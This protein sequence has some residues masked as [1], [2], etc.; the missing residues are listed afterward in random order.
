[1]KIAIVGTRGIPAKYGGFE[2]FAEELSI[3]LVKK[4]IEVDVYCDYESYPYD[5]YK[6]V[7]LKFLDITKTSHPLK[8][9]FQSIVLAERNGSDVILCCGCGGF[10]ALLRH[11]IFCKQGI[12]ITNTDGIEHRRTKWNW[13]LRQCGRFALEYLSVQF[14]N[15][16]IADSEGIRKYLLSSYP[17]SKKKIFTIEYGAYLSPVF[18]E[19]YL[20]SLN[21]KVKE[22][23]LIVSRLEPE[24]NV[25]LII[26]GY[27]KSTS[28]YPLLIVGNLK[29]SKYVNELLSYRSEKIIFI[30]GIYDK[31]KL[32]SIRIGCRAYLHGHSVG[33]TNP[34]LLEAL[35]CGNLVIAHD[36]VFNREVTDNKM[37][38]FADSCECSEAIDKV[39][40]MNNEELERYSVISKDRIM[41]YYNWERITNLYEKM[42]HKVL[43]K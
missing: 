8:Y 21:L 5:K 17:I 31:E 24:N 12:F 40:R 6:G 42:F 27:V 16:L 11:R 29:N 18:L 38:Y 14:S 23:Y 19:Q 1:M 43:M 39:D 37:F 32:S 25:S 20:V 7:N 22:Y 33:G 4:D 30:G 28:V 3:R 2:T 13:F 35:G 41:T 34:S 10:G 36:N 15:Y 26:E 9:Y